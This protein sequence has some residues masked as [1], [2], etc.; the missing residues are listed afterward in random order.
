MEDKIKH[1]PLPWKVDDDK[2]NHHV[3]IVAPW[4][5]VV[6]PGNTST[7]GDYRGAYISKSEWNSGVPTHAQAL[8]NS[9]FIVE[10]C[11]NYY[12][13]KEQN[14]K[15]REAMVYA[16]EDLESYFNGGDSKF[17]KDANN[18]LKEALLSTPLKEE[19]N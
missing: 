5:D 16:Q 8:D 6:T 12:S 3:I 14:E 10:A 1:T 7:F 17:I 15:L 18:W 4:S 13:L 9:Q 19:N 2:E 11:N